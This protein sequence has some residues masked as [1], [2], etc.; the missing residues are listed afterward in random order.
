MQRF[1]QGE[2]S[3]R[4]RH[5]RGTKYLE[6]T[7]TD[8]NTN[9]RENVIFAMEKH[10]HHTSSVESLVNLTSKVGEIANSFEIIND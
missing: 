8:I 4:K 6:N 1:Q 2:R 5:T 9:R 3:K 7:A 10:K